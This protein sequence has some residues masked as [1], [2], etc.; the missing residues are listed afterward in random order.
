MANLLFKPKVWYKLQSAYNSVPTFAAS[1]SLLATCTFSAEVGTEKITDPSA[2]AGLIDIVP[3]E[4]VHGKVGLKVPLSESY[5]DGKFKDILK[6]AGFA[7]TTTKL[8]MGSS[9]FSNNY[10]SLLF[11]VDGFRF[12]LKNAVVT[13]LKLTKAKNGI[14]TLDADF[15]GMLQLSSLPTEPT[16]YNV[17]ASMDDAITNVAIQGVSNYW[18]SVELDIKPQHYTRKDHTTGDLVFLLTKIEATIKYDFDAGVVGSW[19]SFITP[20]SIITQSL[21]LNGSSSRKIDYTG[22][23]ENPAMLKD[24]DGIAAQDIT[25]AVKSLS[26]NFAS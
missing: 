10:A 16:S 1:D 9:L 23:L 20:G 5:W 26:F 22:I 3:T 21:L 12:L 13:G 24:R 7:G 8:D 2:L 17:P 15:E 11:N 25:L 14:L 19:D 4:A 18:A 6:V